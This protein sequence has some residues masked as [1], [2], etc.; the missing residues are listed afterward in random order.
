MHAPMHALMDAPMHHPC[1]RCVWPATM[2]E[3]D[4]VYRKQMVFTG[5]NTS[6]VRWRGRRR[7]QFETTSIKEV[8]LG[9]DNNNYRMKT[10]HSPVSTRCFANCDSVRHSGASCN[11]AATADSITTRRA[12]IEP[13]R[14]CRRRPVSPPSTAAFETIEGWGENHNATNNEN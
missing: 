4:D 5:R 13:E 8:S 6:L 11:E 2:Y 3:R 10:M 14:P 7:W 1:T 9:G 12:W